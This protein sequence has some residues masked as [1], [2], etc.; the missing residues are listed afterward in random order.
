MKKTIMILSVLALIAIAACADGKTGGNTTGN[1]TDGT[2]DEQRICCKA[3][4]ADCLAC[5]QGVTKEE[6]CAESPETVGC[7]QTGRDYVSTDPSECALI[8]YMCADGKVPFEDKTG[9]GC[10]PADD[11]TGDGRPEG[12]VECTEPRPEA[13]T[14]QYDPV[15]ADVDNGIRCVKAPCPSTDR[16]TYGNGCS[17]CG[18]PKVYGYTPGACEE[19]TFAQ[20]VAEG[21]AVMESYPRKC[22]FPDG[23]LVTEDVD[24]A[25]PSL[26]LRPPMAVCDDDESTRQAQEIGYECVEECPEGYDSYMTQIALEVCIA[27][28]GEEEFSLMPECASLDECTSEQ[29]CI[30]T[31]MSTDNVEMSEE[32]AKYRCAP[33]P[34]YDYMLQTGGADT[35]DQDGERSV[36]IA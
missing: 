1:I 25:A 2:G 22:R 9:C 14:M 27:H 4:T 15:C 31:R 34:Y 13:C 21:N 16:K 6:Y 35:L 23:T 5:E 11:G 20:C 10:E 8:R 17:A 7:E 19:R 3:L 36:A 26:K 33:Q 29:V 18:D 30:N 32:I 12:Y 24:G 28:L